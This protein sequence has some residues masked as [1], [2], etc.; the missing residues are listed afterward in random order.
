MY[1]YKQKNINK[2]SNIQYKK[3]LLPSIC[4]I[5]LIL[6][7]G[8]IYLRVY[9]KPKV[10]IDK[11]TSGQTVNYEP[12]RPAEKKETEAN[13]DKIVEQQNAK[14]NQTTSSTDKKTVKPTITNTN[15]SVNAYISGIF[16]E[17]G[18]CTAIFTKENVTLS[19]TSLGFQNVSYTQ[20]APMIIG[21]GFLS[22]GEWNIIVKYSSDKSEGTSDKQ[23]MVI[24]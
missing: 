10:Q 17:G 3:I 15:G 16:E 12:A 6:V 11:N 4:I 13:K 22:P 21:S 20:C 14:N 5:I 8:Y 24:N 1:N 7:G 19:K 23:T 18:T 2:K 9:Q